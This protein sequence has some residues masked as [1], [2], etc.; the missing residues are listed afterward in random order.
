MKDISPRLAS[1]SLIFSQKEIHVNI[2][3]ELDRRLLDLY[4]SSLHPDDDLQTELIT[5]YSAH[6]E[7]FRYGSEQ[8]L[9][10]RALLL[11]GWLLARLLLKHA[12]ET[13]KTPDALLLGLVKQMAETF[14]AAIDAIESNF[15]EYACEFGVER[16]RYKDA[17]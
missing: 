5:I 2:N 13:G 8:S 9:E 6:L 10:P 14:E 15:P 12:G 1:V 4:R 7:Y 3:T 16:Q 17:V 11:R